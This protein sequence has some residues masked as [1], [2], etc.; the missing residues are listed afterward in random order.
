VQKFSDTF[1]ITAA[2][3]PLLKSNC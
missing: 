3:G 1:L 2:H